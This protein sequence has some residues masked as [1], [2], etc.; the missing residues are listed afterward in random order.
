MP[1][2]RAGTFSTRAGGIMASEDNF[3]IRI[4]G[5]GTHAARPHMGID[6]IVIGAQ[7][8]LALQ[9]IVPRNLDPASR[10]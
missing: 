2:M 6:P 9:T 10:P 4:D 3:V 1:G 8:V 7:V 5:R